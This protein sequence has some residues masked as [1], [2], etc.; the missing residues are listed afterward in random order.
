MARSIIYARLH[1]AA[2]FIAFAG[3]MLAAGVY[4]SR[5]W[6][7]SRAPATHEYVLLTY[8]AV[9][10]CLL[11]V[12]LHSR[13]P[14]LARAAQWYPL[15]A[16]GWAAI[17]GGYAL[18]YGA[19]V[20]WR[21]T[22]SAWPSDGAPIA[23]G[24]V[25]LR[26]LSG[27]GL[28][29]GTLALTLP[30]FSPTPLFLTDR[31]HVANWETRRALVIGFIHALVTALVVG[32]IAARGVI[33]AEPAPL[34]Q[35]LVWFSA[36]YVFG[37]LLASR[38]KY[39]QRQMGLMVWAALFT[40]V[41]LLCVWCAPQALWPSFVLG[42]AAGLGHLPARSVVQSSA[43]P[44]QRT[45]ALVLL[46][47]VQLAGVGSAWLLWFGLSA[48]GV[49]SSW[50]HA[51]FFAG[52]VV[53][54]VSALWICR[55]EVFEVSMDMTVGL[56]YPI[57]AYGAGVLLLPVRGP[58]LI[59]AN[60]HAMLDPL[61][62]SKIVPMKVTALM[63]SKFFDLPIIRFLV[64]K[65][66]CAIRVPDVTF[67][68]EAPEIQEAVAAIRRGETVMIFPEGWLRRKEQIPI[69]RFG[70]GAFQILKAEP[71]TPVIACWV[72]GG[73]GSI[74][75]FKNGPP[76]KGKPFDFLKCI[77]IGVCV[78]EV[79][80]PE[81]LNDQ[82]ATRAYLQQKVVDARGYLDLPPIVPPEPAS[83]NDEPTE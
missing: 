81:L 57:R 13:L 14:A 77:R 40:A 7:A 64:T 4:G 31:Q 59:V 52:S 34:P 54:A 11:V 82:H 70:Q 46:V 50:L 25:Y 20:H 29:I 37:I 6:F 23:N 60:H 10:T 9:L 44:D 32:L 48:L 8:S 51:A 53:L 30:K 63:T 55:R 71:T 16:G 28:A 24:F 72:E 1:L 76:G 58:A 56:N 39:P 12:L 38:Q 2:L 62:L 5:W 67:R 74:T 19:T 73:W 42:V 22:D 26:A 80:P 45:L 3:W 27:L 78:P 66:V 43:P 75:S 68:R 36:A 47:V 18:W 33:H 69:R 41:A 15:R 49:A 83:E 17:L 79:L 35:A 61:W 21:G 65:V